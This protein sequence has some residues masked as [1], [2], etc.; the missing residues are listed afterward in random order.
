MMVNTS[1]MIGPKNE[2]VLKKLKQVAPNYKFIIN[3]LG[4]WTGGINTDSGATN[5]KLGSDMGEGVTGGGLV[6]KDLSKADVSVNIYCFVRA[7]I[8]KKDVHATCNI[9][10]TYVDV[11]GQK[12]PY[13]D[14]VDVAKKFIKEIGGFEEFAKWGLIRQNN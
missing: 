5:R 2:K 13:K 10:D 4:E 8:I 12:I 14:I 7:Q 3:P 11:D 1:L 9:G 6:G